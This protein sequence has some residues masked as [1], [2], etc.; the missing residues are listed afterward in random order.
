M[1]LTRAD[2]ETL[3]TGI[4]HVDVDGAAVPVGVNLHGAD[5]QGADLTGL[6]LPHAT[7][8]GANCGGVKFVRCN[9]KGANFHGANLKGAVLS[10]AQ[11]DGANFCGA[12]L[13]GALLYS[14]RHPHANFADTC[15]EGTEGVGVCTKPCTIKELADNPPTGRFTYGGGVLTTYDMDNGANVSDLSLKHITPAERVARASSHA[16]RVQAAALGHDGVVAAL[17]SH[18]AAGAAAARADS[19]KIHRAHLAALL[20]AKGKY[21]E[22]DRLARIEIAKKRLHLL[23]EAV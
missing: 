5:L 18:R 23:G 8:H 22:S 4:P 13:C 6:A 19:V 17:G 2:V 15:M 10:G 21:K 12:C 16:A 3:I 9:L 20:A 7:F 14:A 11:L 1:P